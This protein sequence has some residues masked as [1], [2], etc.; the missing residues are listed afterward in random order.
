MKAII[1]PESLMRSCWKY[2]SLCG[3]DSNRRL[4]VVAVVS[5]CEAKCWVHSVIRFLGAMNMRRAAPDAIKHVDGRREF[6]A[7]GS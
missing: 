3:N 1:V 7:R 5:H 2:S 6:A 4:T